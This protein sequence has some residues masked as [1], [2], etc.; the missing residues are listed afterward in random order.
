MG[1]AKFIL[2]STIHTL[3]TQNNLKLWNK[4]VSD[5]CHLCKNRDSTLHTLSGCKV[6]LEQKRYTWRHDNIINY[7]VQCLDSTKVTVYSDIEGHQASNGGSMPPEVLVTEQ[8]PDIVVINAE[9]GTVK[10]LELTV[11]F[12]GNIKERNKDKTDKYAHFLTDIKTYAP[13]L[14]CFE[15]GVRGYLTKDNM[16]KLKDIHSLCKKNIKYKT[17][18]KNISAISIISSYYIFTARKNPTWGITSCLNAPFQH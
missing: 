12:E 6:S 8:K 14:T 5:K 16:D 2:N 17:F 10:L 18:L 11:P 9:K 15:V 1:T 4:S 13:S 3:P 7:I